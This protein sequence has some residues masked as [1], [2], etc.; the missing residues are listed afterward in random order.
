MGDGR[1]PE[2]ECGDTRLPPLPLPLPALLMLPMRERLRSVSR[3]SGPGLRGRFIP[4][5]GGDAR[6]DID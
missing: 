1:P 4:D 6:D 2:P 5:E 3:S